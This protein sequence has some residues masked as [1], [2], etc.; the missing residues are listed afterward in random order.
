ME[1]E[2][3]CTIESD[4]GVFTELMEQ[5]GVKNCQVV[6]L[7]S[8]DDVHKFQPVHGLIF[9]FKWQSGEVDNRAVDSLSDIFFANQVINNACATQALLSIL[10]NVKGV[11]VGEELS[12]LKEF[13]KDLPPEMKGLA[14]GN[15]DMIRKAHNSFARPEPFEYVGGTPPED[16]EDVYHFISY[17]HYE[18]RLFE[19]DGLKQG[20]IDLGECTSQDWLEKVGPEIQK[21]IERYSRSEIRF[22]LMALTGNRLQLFTASIADLE[23]ERALLQE[24]I[25]AAESGQPSSTDDPVEVLRERLASLEQQLSVAQQGLLEEQEK[26]KAWKLENVR[27]RHNYIPFIM[28]MLRILAEKG[29]LLTLIEQAKEKESKK[30]AEPKAKKK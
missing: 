18:G 4:P 24:Q 12:Q 7:Y 11:D 28:Q 22:N 10:L 2:G 5:L 20:P 19:L 14:I 9:L 21:R 8:L 15:S 23:K 30:K 13:S 1:G 16:P 29:E 27:R 25:S 3:W 17:L 6:E 26:R